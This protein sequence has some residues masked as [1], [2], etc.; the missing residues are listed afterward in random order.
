VCTV[1]AKLGVK[2]IIFI[3]SVSVYGFAPAGIDETGAVNYFND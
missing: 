1:C 3:S 2:K